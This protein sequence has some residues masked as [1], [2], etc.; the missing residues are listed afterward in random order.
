MKTSRI[1]WVIVILLLLTQVYDFCHVIYNSRLRKATFTGIE[2]V[3]V[4]V[5]V[6]VRL[7]NSENITKKVLLYRGAVCKEDPSCV[8]S[9][10]YIPDDGRVLI[11]FSKMPPIFVICSNFIVTDRK[12]ELELVEVLKKIKPSRI[13][14]PVERKKNPYALE[15]DEKGELKSQEPEKTEPEASPQGE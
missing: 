10:R 3:K 15:F 7:S 14:E 9:I 8:C 13:F 2:G 6:P 5:S 4:S 1:L 12:K 11:R